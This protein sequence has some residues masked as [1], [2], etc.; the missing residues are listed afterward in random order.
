MSTVLLCFITF[1]VQISFKSLSLAKNSNNK[2][3]FLG[4]ILA[5]LKF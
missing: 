1:V 3:E 2:R 5:P 4:L